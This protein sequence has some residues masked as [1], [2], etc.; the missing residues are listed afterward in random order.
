MDDFLVW[1]PEEYENLTQIVLTPDL[2]WLPDFGIENSAKS[3]YDELHFKRFRVSIL[4]NGLLN[5]VPG[6]KFLTSCKLDIT[7]YP[8]DDQECNIDFV[9]WAYHGLQVNLINGSSEIGLDAYT[10]SGEWK[11][12]GTKA[13]SEDQFYESDP[14]V[15]FPRV[16]FTLFLRRK[17][18]FYLINIITPCMTMSLL[19]LLVFYLPPDSGEKVSLGIT[20]LLSFSVFLL[21]VAENVPKTS[22][23]IP[24]LGK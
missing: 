11:I 12:I 9:D 16:R 3:I 17:P 4:H 14:G 21:L 10:E 19:A 6:G 15:P 2:I 18:M 23:F 13:V 5:W 22:E 20:V 7:F 8:F 24:L 1:N